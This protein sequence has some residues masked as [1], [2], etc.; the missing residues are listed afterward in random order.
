MHEKYTKERKEPIRKQLRRLQL[1]CILIKSKKYY[2]TDRRQVSYLWKKREVEIRK[3]SKADTMKTR[4]RM[5]KIKLLLSSL[6][7]QIPSILQEPLLVTL[8]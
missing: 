7:V 4:N 8:V 5:E 1:P 6:H 2:P 3:V